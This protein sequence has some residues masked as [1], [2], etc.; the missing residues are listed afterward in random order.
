[1]PR[2]ISASMTKNTSRGNKKRISMTRVRTGS[3]KARIKI[4]K[5]K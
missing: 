1:M 3:K 5:K 4:S 2:A